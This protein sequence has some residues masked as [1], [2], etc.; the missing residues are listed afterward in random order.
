MVDLLK[1]MMNLSNEDSQT[2]RLR[3]KAESIVIHALSNEDKEKNV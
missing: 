1:H 3:R 2:Q